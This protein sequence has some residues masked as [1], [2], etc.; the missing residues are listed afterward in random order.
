M[1]SRRIFRI[2]GLGVSALALLM[3]VM[4]PAI[5]QA[6]NPLD[7]PGYQDAS[8][9]PEQRAADLVSRMTLE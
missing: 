3:C 9:T 8:K 6:Q 4:T 7:R 2:S 5:V 1:T